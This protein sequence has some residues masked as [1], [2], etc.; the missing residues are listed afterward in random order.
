[1]ER[2]ALI[3]SFEMRETD[4]CSVPAAA[5]SNE[6]PTGEAAHFLP[7]GFDVKRLDGH[8]PT[9]QHACYR[10]VIFER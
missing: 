3:P 7:F 1:M 9:L 4:C 2:K 6:N 5:G 10:P 8:R